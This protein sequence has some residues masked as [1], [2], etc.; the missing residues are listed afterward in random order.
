MSWTIR[1]AATCA[2]VLAVPVVVAAPAVAASPISLT[3]GF[4]V[5]PNSSPAVWA[6]NNPG[7]SR[8]ARIQ[9]AIGSKPIARWFGQ[10]PNIGSTVANYMGAADGNDKLPVLVA[11]NLPGRDACGGQSGGGAGSVSAYRT[12]IS[13]FAAGIGTK[14][15]VVI[16][17]PD[18]LGD[19]ECMTQTQINDRLGMLT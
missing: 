4:Y 10:D 18:A 8:A 15:A 6:R 5:N 7:D 11:Y 3:S 17:E 12:W 1:L 16:I 19:F 2:C 9:S 13:S 14:P